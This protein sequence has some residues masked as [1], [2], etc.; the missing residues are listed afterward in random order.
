MYQKRVRE[1]N[2]KKMF[3]YIHR[4]GTTNRLTIAR[5]LGL[6]PSAVTNLAFELM[7][8]G[9]IR[10]R[11][12]GQ[13][14]GGR[15]PALICFDEEWSWVVTVKIGAKM[16]HAGLANLNGKIKIKR[17]EA[18]HSYDPPDVVRQI[19]TLVRSLLPHSKQRILGMGICCTGIIDTE[20]GEVLKALNLGWQNVPLKTYVSEYFEWPIFVEDVGDTGALGEKWFGSGKGVENLVFVTL[21]NGIGAGIICNGELYV[22]SQHAAGEF[23]HVSIDFSGPKCVCG[24]RGCLELYASA[25]AIVREVLGYLDGGGETIIWELLQGNLGNLD[26]KIVDLA[27]RRGDPF[28]LEIWKKTGELLGRAISNLVTLFD[29]EMVIIGGGLSLTHHAFF[30]VVSHTLELITMSLRTKRVQVKKAFFGKDSGL[31]GAAALIVENIFNS[32][33]EWCRVEEAALTDTI[34]G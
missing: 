11:G 6:S 17:V 14:I 1:E 26:C 21:G 29:P 32:K 18:I 4:A 31:V 8:T 5:E 24:N 16:V 22:G 19:V 7:H 12:Y 9:V 30:D 33:V 3:R 27:A 34:S 25:P 10:E 2:L 23:G 28:A 15:K 20:N 13:S